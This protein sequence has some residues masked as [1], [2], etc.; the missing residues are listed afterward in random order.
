MPEK[1]LK[2]YNHQATEP[3]IYKKWEES[4]YFNPDNLPGDRK[5]PY[6]IIM[7]PPNANGSLHVGHALFVTL[8]DLLVRY[9]RMRGYKTLWLP[10]MDHAGFETQIVYEKKLEKE[11][12]SRFKMERDEFYKETLA[13]TMENKKFTEGQLRQLGA[14]CDWSREKFT[15]DPDIVKIVYGTFKQLYDDGLAYRGV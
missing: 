5:E 15:L 9:K 3:D 13:F 1:F 14:S 12:R 10:G 2:P 6:T 7:P 4:G 11:G 8:Q